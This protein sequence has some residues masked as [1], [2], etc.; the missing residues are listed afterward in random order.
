MEVR[1]AMPGA[2]RR[3]P[4]ILLSAIALLS[5]AAL[6]VA[7]PAQRAAS[8]T[9]YGN[10]ISWQ[11][12]AVTTPSR[13]FTI[14]GSIGGLWPGK[15]ARLVLAVHNPQP[16]AIAVT[17]ISTTVESPGVPCAASALSVRAFAG[18]LH[19]G[20]KA[21]A[22]VSVPI[23]LAHSAPDACEGAVFP[24]RYNGRGVRR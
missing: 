2:L 5:V 13:T 10:G 24:L 22:H 20:A 14:S 9:L 23:T 11:T 8:A 4:A 12:T 18:M 1:N 16:Y 21:T 17:S 19:V 6:T 7:L 3:R 15:A